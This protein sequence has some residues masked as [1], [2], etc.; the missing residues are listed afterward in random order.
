MYKK[1]ESVPNYP[2]I[3]QEILDFWQKNNIK[4]KVLN[5]NSDSDKVFSF[6][7]GPPTA[8]GEPHAGH[9]L[10]RSLKD[11]YTRFAGMN[12][13]FVPRKGGWDTHGLPVE[14]AV[15]KSLNISGKHEIEE[16][17]VEKFIAECKKN[18]WLCIDMWKEFSDAVGYSLDLE[19]DCYNPYENY[20]IESIWWSLDEF[21]KKGLL[22]KGYKVLPS[23]TSCQTALSSH[24]VAQGY[25][26]KTDI[27]VTVRVYCEELNAYFL[28]WTTTPWTL[29]SNVGLCVNPKEEYSLVEDKNKDRYILAS[30]LVSQNFNEEP[31][32]ID[33]YKGSELEG[34]RYV[35]PFESCSDKS[36]TGYRVVSDS[37][38]TMDSGTGIV[39]ISPAYGEDDN[40]V[41]H[42]WDLP[43]LHLVDQSGF[44][45]EEAKNY[46]GKHIFDESKNIILDLKE[47]GKLFSKNK[48]TH[49]Y[50]HC[51]RCNSPLIYFARDAWFLKTTSYRDELLEGNNAINWFPKSFKDGRM[52]N[53]IKNNVD[54]CLSRN[55]F[56]GTPLNVWQCEC[57]HY[58]TIGSIDELVRLSGCDRNIELHKP[59]IDAVMIP[60]E[61]CD[62]TMK[63]E[64]EVIDVWYDSGAMPFAQH[65]YPFENKEIFE[66]RYPADFIFEGY[67]Q[68]RGWFYSLE[69]VNIGLFNAPPMKNCLANGMICDENGQKMSKRKGNYTDPMEF[70]RKYGGDTVRFMFY[71]NSQ[72]Y[73]DVIFSENL[74]IE[75]QRK[76][77]NTMYSSFAF[78]VLYAEID[79]FKSADVN[80]DISQLTIMDRFILSKLN[81]L[82]RKVH[83]MVSEYMATEASREI[84]A[85]VDELSN[86]YI[87]RSRKR[88]WAEGMSD[89]KRA[90]LSTLYTII[91]TL[92]KICA[93]FIPF[94]SE[95]I[96]QT[97]ERPFTKNSPES[98]HLCAFPKPNMELIDDDIEREMDIAYRYCELGRSA[99]TAANLKIRQPLKKMFIKNNESDALM[100]DEYKEIIKDELN[101]KEIIENEDINQYVVYSLRPQLKTLGPKYNKLIGAIKDYLVSCDA[102]EVVKIVMNGETHQTVIDGTQILFN[103]DDL[104][105]STSEMEGYSGAS[106]EKLSI[107]LDISISDELTEEYYCREFV[108][109]IQALRKAHDFDIMAKAN[110]NIDGDSE[111]ISILLKH[112]M[113]LKNDIYMSSLTTGKPSGVQENISIDDYVIHVSISV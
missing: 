48:F 11:V 82:I 22:Y 81:T 65:H 100:P 47:N 5:F 107:V 16:F 92:S 50:P 63:R 72:P 109:K 9:V 105:I 69:A 30:T 97:I 111:I 85:F 6:Y 87:R 98:I 64:S 33:R 80:I 26:D 13:Y 4:K 60:C 93:P 29:L 17:G 77:M 73:N 52:G 35:P 110:V 44:F 62:K 19:E 89:D 99:R 45:T 28:I 25:K 56:W 76:F 2:R 55:R 43:F 68:T 113:Q 78:F 108:S 14:I 38:V 95:E 21:N 74:L 3:E 18:V 23:C 67:D 32:I 112:H 42:K 101:I 96:Y 75:T 1:L 54:W 61:K 84:A 41:A 94:I 39:H 91:S 53:F 46:A 86:W 51:W 59:Y 15:E 79:N 58:K 24:E 7:E 90:A 103:R 20:F 36:E 106:D 34:K 104:L 10:T 66:R 8:N 88:F 37:Y 71:T 31:T 27:T 57:G 12:G 49:N 40:K 70:I 102:S 83:K